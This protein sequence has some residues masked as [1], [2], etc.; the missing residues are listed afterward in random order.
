MATEVMERKRYSEEE[1]K[2]HLDATEKMS[3]AEQKVYADGA[4]ISIHTLRSWRRAKDGTTATAGAKRGR[5]RPPGSKNKKRG[6]GRPPGT[7]NKQPAP[8]KTGR[9]PG[10]PKGSGKKA[11]AVVAKSSNGSL[12]QRVKDLLVADFENRLAGGE[13]TLDA[14]MNAL[15]TDVHN[16]L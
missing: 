10:R 2:K 9:G 7:K 11:A 14:S 1:K 16:A 8:K 15:L 12:K 4:G 5:G 6:P 3:Y 13:G